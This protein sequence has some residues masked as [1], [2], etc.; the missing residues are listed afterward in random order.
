MENPFPGMETKVL[1]QGFHWLSHE[2]N[3]YWRFI[4][5]KAPAIVRDGFDGIW[6]PPP[7]DS[8]SHE[9]YLP[10]KLHCL[11]SS[12]G[13]RDEFTTCIQQL[14]ASGLMPIL[15]IVINHRVGTTHASDFTEPYWPLEAICN[16]DPVSPGL[17][18]AS[19]GKIFE[20]GRNINH[21]SLVVQN[22]LIEWLLN[23]KNIGIRGWRF[24]YVIGYCSSFV[25][26]YIDATQPEFA[27]GEYW[28]DLNEQTPCLHRQALIKWIG[29]AEFRSTAFDMTL[30]GMLQY[31]ISTEQ[32]Q[33]LVC[34]EKNPVGLMGTHP[35]HSVTFIDNHD[36]GLS[37]LCGRGQNHWPFPNN[38]LIQGYAYILTHP[39]IPCVYWLHMYDSELGKDIKRLIA[40]R[41]EYGIKSNSHYEMREAKKGL[42]AAVIDNKLAIKLG[43]HDWCPGTGELLYSYHN[44][45]LWAI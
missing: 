25:K 12:Y 5:E 23:L 14:N 9:G 1:L 33:H 34:A 22:S 3:S 17:G 11:D 8:L 39:G 18:E 45:A 21:N 29:H 40:I 7:S 27:V 30:K 6:L 28:D 19:T 36:T 24:D 42:Y 32:Y 16:D 31:A 35:Q 13:T 37:S 44:C 4:A 41:K 38:A 43:S 10:R 2:L 26:T 15:D 20:G